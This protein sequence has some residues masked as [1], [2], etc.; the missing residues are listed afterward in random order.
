VFSGSADELLELLE[1][2][3]AAGC[4]HAIINLNPCSVEA[5]ERVAEVRAR[6]SV[7]NG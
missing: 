5:I 3:A 6:L 4:G 7:N 1:E 2:F